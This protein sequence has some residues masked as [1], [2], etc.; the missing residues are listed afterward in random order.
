[1]NPAGRHAPASTDEVAAL[2]RQAAASR[3]R[4]ILPARRIGRA[5]PRGG[6]VL[7]LH[8]LATVVEVNQVARFVRAQ[9]GVTLGDLDAD[10]QAVGLTIGPLAER[11]PAVLIGVLLQAPEAADR[12]PRHGRFVDQCLGLEAVLADGT[13]VVW[14][15]SPRKAA[16]PD[17][18]A[19]LAGTGA[20]VG[21]VTAV[22]LRVHGVPQAIR[23]RAF[24]FATRAAAL[25]AS[26]EAALRDVRPATWWWS[27]GTLSARLEGPAAIVDAEERTLDAAARA[28]RGRP[29]DASPRPVGPSRHASWSEMLRRSAAV[30]EM[31]LDGGCLY[32]TGAPAARLPA[33]IIH[34]LATRSAS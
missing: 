26:R 14:R 15:D 5:R 9:A 21:V 6:V 1:M 28:E 16:G 22:T 31:T 2:L 33:G 4:V 8:R 25:R 23:N 7:D 27:K 12:S 24:A 18:R 11:Y 10:L 30:S 3:Q 13:V 17:W 19:L 29:A 32:G 20:T 34:A